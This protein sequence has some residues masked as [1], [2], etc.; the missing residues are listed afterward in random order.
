MKLRIYFSCQYLFIYVWDDSLF[1]PKSYLLRVLWFLW[2]QSTS[3][4][5]PPFYFHP[6]WFWSLFHLCF[7]WTLA[8]G[9]DEKRQQMIEE[10]VT[11]LVT[12]ALLIPVSYQ[13]DKWGA[14]V[15]GVAQS[16]HMDKTTHTRTSLPT[17]KQAGKFCCFS[18]LGATQSDSGYIFFLCPA[19]PLHKKALLSLNLE[20]FTLNSFLVSRCSGK[21]VL[22]R[23]LMRAFKVTNEADLGF[24]WQG[25]WF[26]K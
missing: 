15:G 5:P 17:H 8:A 13:G 2:D 19:A 16:M 14:S 9:T 12:D 4:T 3:P 18:G 20:R 11:H 25:V 21:K 10:T 23:N 1:A 7:C 6:L 24:E 22:H 26:A